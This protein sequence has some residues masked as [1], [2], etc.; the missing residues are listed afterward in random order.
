MRVHQITC[1][2]CGAGMKSEAGI[3][4]GRT[5]PCPKCKKTFAVEAV[6]EAELVDDAEVVEDFEPDEPAPKKKGPPPARGK[7]PS[8]RDQDDETE[9]EEPL[10]KKARRR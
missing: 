1:P 7:K 10:P 6:D 8:R 9:E 3:R 2:H 5:V 4:A